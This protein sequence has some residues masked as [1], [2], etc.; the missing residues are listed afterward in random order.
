[1]HTAGKLLRFF[2]VTDTA[3]LRLCSAKYPRLGRQQIVRT[4]M[5]NAAIG[6][7]LVSIL[8]GLP[9]DS[10]GIFPCLIRMA[11]GANRLWDI[12]RVR[13]GPKSLVPALT[14]QARMGA[15]LQL[16]RLSVTGG[17]RRVRRA[18]G[19]TKRPQDHN[20]IATD[21]RAAKRRPFLFAT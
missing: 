13:I 16:L 20:R 10:E 6:R 14:G 2:S 21:K 19:D 9:M 4:A 18:Q 12:R 17:A 8:A 3:G 15:L 5:A 11:S 7:R 1:M